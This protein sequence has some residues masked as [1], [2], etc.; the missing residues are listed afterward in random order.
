MWVYTGVTSVTDDRGNIG[1]ILVNQRTKEAHYYSCAGAEEY[2]AMSSAEG[3]LQQ[4]QYTAT[5]PLLLNISDQP[6]YFMAMKD[7]AGLVKMYAMV[8]V[9]QYQIVA[10]GTTVENCQQN[11][12]D[13]M[14]EN[15]ILEEEEA[16]PEGADGHGN[17]QNGTGKDGT[18]QE[19]EQSAPDGTVTG[20]IAEIRSAVIDGNTYYYLRLENSED[21]YTVS[22]GE[23]PAA[24]ILNVGDQITIS[25]YGESGPI[26][27]GTDLRTE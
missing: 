7:A 18:D 17:G 26:R 11:Y 27:K 22:A 25:Y 12:H 9:Q 2:S 5:F 24:V 8:N 23:Y 1:F 14:V 21:Y 3:A 20:R 16:V 15:G 10:T 6:T 4:Y 19:P 13:L